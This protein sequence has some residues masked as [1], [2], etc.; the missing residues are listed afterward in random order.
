MIFSQRHQQKMGKQLNQ[1]PERR[2]HRPDCVQ[3]LLDKPV[4][5]LA[6]LGLSFPIFQKKGFL[7][8]LSMTSSTR[9]FPFEGR[10]TESQSLGA[11]SVDKRPLSPVSSLCTDTACL[12]LLPLTRRQRG[13]SA[14][15]TPCSPHQPQEAGT[16]WDEATSC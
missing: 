9:T 11:A 10:R 2:A 14:L 7:D 4:R 12:V 6:S 1:R 16:T 8:M 15:Q 13:P 3:S 5:S